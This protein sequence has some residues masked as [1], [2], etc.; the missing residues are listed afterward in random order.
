M[1]V[2]GQ[3][4]PVD[5]AV[6]DKLQGLE[7]EDSSQDSD[8]DEE[9]LDV[10]Y[11]NDNRLSGKGL[12]HFPLQDTPQSDSL[13]YQLHTAENNLTVQDS[14]D[15]YSSVLPVEDSAISISHPERN[16]E[17]PSQGRSEAGCVSSAPS[18]SAVPCNLH[19]EP[20][21]VSSPD[22]RQLF[23]E[24]VVSPP[25]FQSFTSTLSRDLEQNLSRLLSSSPTLSATHATNLK[26]S[27]SSSLA[28][29][30]V[31]DIQRVNL[32]ITTL[33]ALVSSVTNGRCHLAFRDKVLTTQALEER[34][35]PVLPILN[36]F[37]SG[38]FSFYTQTDR[39]TNN[40]TG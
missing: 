38:W 9:H 32:D 14:K 1:Q 8:C 15:E 18:A 35:A 36:R 23:L 21:C 7:S 27:T 12:D 29:E 11:W 30:A 31:S 10:D 17:L 3:R 33:I 16:M 20:D 39:Q 40:Q 24:L 6:L 26:S 4:V 28:A 37:L 13:L 19:S 2:W 34:Q 25:D 22:R 5:S